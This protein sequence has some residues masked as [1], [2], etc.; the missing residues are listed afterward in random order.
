VAGLLTSHFY[1][2]LPV[3]TPLV[4][5]PLSLAVYFEC[6][7]GDFLRCREKCHVSVDDFD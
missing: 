2:P 6:L 1:K 7:D 5:A 4:G 3:A